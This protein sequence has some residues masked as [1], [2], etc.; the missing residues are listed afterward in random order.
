MEVGAVGGRKVGD[1]L[2]RPGG[3]QVA[4]SLACRG[5]DSKNVDGF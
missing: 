4:A 1:E 3:G 5:M 2:R